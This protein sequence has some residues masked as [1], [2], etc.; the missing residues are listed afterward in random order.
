MT[1]LIDNDYKTTLAELIANNELDA[2]TIQELKDL[3]VNAAYFIGCSEIT[4]TK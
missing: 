4:K 2:A 1:F 3:E